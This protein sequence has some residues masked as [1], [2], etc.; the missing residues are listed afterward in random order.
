[1]TF[2]WPLALLGL[3]LLPLVLVAYLALQRRRSRYA[4]RFTNLDLLANVVERTPSWRRHVPPA[5]FLVAL[6]LLLTGVAR[7]QATIKVPRE[8]AGV[9]LAVDVSGSMRAEDVEPT[10]LDAA[11]EA[12]E[13]FLDQLPD[14]FSVGLVSFSGQAQVLAPLTPEREV[15][16]EALRYLHADGGTAIGDAI[17]RSVE[18]GRRDEGETGPRSGGAGDG[19]PADGDDPPLAAIVLLSD[20]APSPGTLD[21]AQAARTASEAGVPIYTIALGTEHGTVEVVGP[22]GERQIIP[23]PPDERTMRQVADITGGEFF[24]AATDDAVRSVY[25]QLGS[26]I[27]WTEERTDVTFAFAAGGAVLLLL[28]GALSALWFGRLP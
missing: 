17:V 21:P 18:L 20:G 19:E 28:A 6:A 26:R 10:R 4:L 5:L 15:V 3:L 14:R 12:A 13:T 2:E 22:Y 25:E 9:V 23:V 7:P 16:R 1:M 11:R 27:G 24:A 8:E